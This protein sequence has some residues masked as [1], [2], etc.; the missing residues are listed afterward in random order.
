MNGDSQF[1][2][3]VKSFLKLEVAPHANQMD[4]ESQTLFNALRKL[5]K[6]EL[7]ALRVPQRWGGKELSDATFNDFQEL[8]ARYSGALAFLQTQH[9]SAAGMLVASNNRELQQKYLPRMGNGEILLGIG[10]SQLRRKGQPSIVA[11]PVEGGYQL[12]GDVPWVTGWGIFSEFIV[13]AT[14]PDGKAVF[15]IVSLVDSKQDE[16]GS[17]KLSAVA[18]LA[19]MTATNTVTAKL[20]SWFL[21]A[22]DVVFVKPTGWIHEND[23]N[24]VLKASFLATG[25]ALAGLDIIETVAK[26]K[27]LPFIDAAF[28]QLS[29]EVDNCRVAIR[30][31]QKNIHLGMA[32]KLKL[33]VWAIDLAARV[34]HAAV[35]VSSGAANYQNHDAQRVYREA[36]VFT[37]TGQTQEVMAGTLARLVGRKEELG[38]I[39]ATVADF[40]EPCSVRSRGTLNLE[41]AGCKGEEYDTSFKYSDPN[42]RSSFSRVIHL[43]HVVDADIPQ[44]QD[45]PKV[46]FTTIAR[47]ETQGYFLRELQIGEHSATHMNAPCSFYDNAKSIDEYAADSLIVNAVVI[48]ICKQVQEDPNYQLSVA[49]AI[50]WEQQQGL[51]PPQSLVLLH[52]G[53]GERWEN[54]QAFMN[55]DAEGNMNFPGFSLDA[56]KF[57]LDSRQAAGIG[58][59]THGVDGGEDTT[60]AVNRLVLAKQK[61]V[62]EN[63]A[64]LEQLPPKG[65]TVVIGILRLRHGSGS[66]VG[67]LALLPDR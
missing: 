24:N 9:Q 30:A 53:W 3:R 49:D 26:S 38:Q 63:L 14:L 8:V 36:L 25:C 50:A 17:I 4:F 41:G 60:F 62:L 57:L 21:A 13:A 67:I 27:N 32:E 33:R 18:S 45:D 61:I 65:I 15:S 2:N 31:A 64:N 22:A 29:Q 59:D 11:T 54:P 40:S 35:T 46:K 39:S 55:Q 5:G 66:P 20:N 37:V 51:I 43:S 10:F 16:G 1:I 44:W 58:I 34:S 6:K 42:T 7:L 56:V 28:S 48:D 52:T 47:I 19:A 23:Q 12:D